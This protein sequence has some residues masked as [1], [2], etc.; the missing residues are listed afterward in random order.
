MTRLLRERRVE[1]PGRFGIFDVSDDDFGGRLGRSVPFPVVWNPQFG[2]RRGRVDHCEQ[3]FSDSGN[4]SIRLYWK[5]IRT[6]HC[7]LV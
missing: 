1:T 3:T 6:I 2:Y 7:D 4:D 5:V